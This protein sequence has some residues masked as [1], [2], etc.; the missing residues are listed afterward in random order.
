MTRVVFF[1]DFHA[2]I[3]EDFSKPDPDYVND[4]FR[5]QID[6]LKRV[7]EIARENNATLVFGGDL[8]HKRSKLE[9]VVFNNVYKVF[10]ENADVPTYLVRGN[11]DSKNNT[12]DTEHWLETFKYLPHVT[13]FS[14][15][16]TAYVN[17]F[18]VYAIPYSDDV[19]YLKQKIKEFAEH[20][21]TNTHPSILVAHVGVDGSEVGRY[22]HRLEGAFTVN[23]MCPDVFD[24]VCLG[25]YHKRQ[26]LGDR[27]NVFYVGNTIQTSFS[28]EGQ[29]KGVFLIDFDKGGKPQFISIPNKKFI[30]LTEVD[31]DTQELI[32]NNYVR[33][34]LPQ[35]QAQV[36]ET[37]KEDSDNIRI[38]IQKEYKTEARID[39]SVDSNEEQIVEAYTK[40][41][42]PEVTDLAIDVLKEAMVK[43]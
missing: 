9:D 42:Y 21:K 38:E 40:E 23:D 8:F 30:T 24:Y 27:D 6:T 34:I 25:H 2:H 43:H 10:A 39:I 18:Q 29:D 31:E 16:D 14:T 17:G 13:V 5:A 37:F 36:V 12:T 15:P 11:H 7:F 41:F 3:F 4:R 26:F 22:S 35:S 28:D 33:L 19:D 32:D 20:R 1:S